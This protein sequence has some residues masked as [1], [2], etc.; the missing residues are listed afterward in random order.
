MP[1]RLPFLAA[2]AALPLLA[3][4]LAAQNCGPMDTPVF[5]GQDLR[6]GTATIENDAADLSISVRL[7]RPWTIH[8]VHFYAGLD[9]VPTNPG[10]NVAPGQFPYKTD[11][12]PNVAEHQEDMPLSDLGA[13]CGDVLYVALH[14][15]VQWVDRY[16]NIRAEETAWA[17]GKIPFTGSQWGWQN[18]YLLCCDD[19]SAPAPDVLALQAGSPL[20]GSFLELRARRAWPGEAVV[21]FANAGLL[22]PASL[23]G[24]PSPSGLLLAPP[25]HPLGTARAGSSGEAVLPAPVPASLRPGTWLGFQ[26][27]APESGRLSPPV[28]RRAGS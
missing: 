20:P 18:S 7:D 3:A 22:L 5:A 17:H 10:D 28:L 21:F 1:F 11:Y 24:A 2:A 4:P 12:D 15:E 9:P 13:A 8:A 23:P 25:V 6:V 16:G 26:A 14:L 27:F 19:G